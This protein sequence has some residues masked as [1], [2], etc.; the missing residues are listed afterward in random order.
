MELRVCCISLLLVVLA[1]TSA[2]G[3][4]LGLESMHCCLFVCIINRKLVH[5]AT[6]H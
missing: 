1:F 5:V 4:S 3:Q 2:H 6:L